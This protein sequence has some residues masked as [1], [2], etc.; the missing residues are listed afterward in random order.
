M[1]LAAVRKEIEQWAPD[2][3]DRLAA[4]LSV[5]RLK[6][7]PRHAAR[8]AERLDDKSAAQWVTFDELKRRLRKQAREARLKRSDISKATKRVRERN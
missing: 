2:D 5:L 1:D 6:R 8:L 7:D 4:M 3:Q